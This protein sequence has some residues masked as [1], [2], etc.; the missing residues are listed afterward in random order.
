LKSC[1]VKVAANISTGK[2]IEKIN[3]LDEETIAKL[4]ETLETPNP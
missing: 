1:D 3:Q 2:L 4:Q